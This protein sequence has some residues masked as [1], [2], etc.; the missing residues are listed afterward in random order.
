VVG[1]VAGGAI[2]ASKARDAT[3]DLGRIWAEALYSCVV[4]Y[5]EITDEAVLERLGEVPH[6][7]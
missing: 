6:A 3:E 4:D 5:T 1:S 7:S 2:T